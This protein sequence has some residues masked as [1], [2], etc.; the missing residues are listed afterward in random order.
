MAAIMEQ[1]HE[2]LSPQQLLQVA[3]ME[4]C[5]PETDSQKLRVAAQVRI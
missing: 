5:E 3:S 2:L 1:Q 4:R